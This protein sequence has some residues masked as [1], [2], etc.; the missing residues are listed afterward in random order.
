V[1]KLYRNDGGV[2]VESGPADD[3]LPG[4]STSSVAWGDYD[5]DGDLDILLTG[6]TGS[7]VARVYRNEG[8]VFVAID[9]AFTGVSYSSVA[10]GDYDNDGDLDILLTGATGSPVTRLY[11]NEECADLAVVKA[12]T[13][14]S[15][16]PGAAITYTVRF[17]NTG[18]GSARGVVI[19][20]SVPVSVTVSRVTSSTVGSGVRITQTSAGPNFAWA[21]S[22]LAVGARGA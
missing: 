19:R 10:W 22:D 20:D 15:A 14:A 9:A 8:G 5:N 2:F 21:V 3:A 17:T 6:A 7:P 12:V 1:A 16:A 13:P 4:V 11:R 18:P